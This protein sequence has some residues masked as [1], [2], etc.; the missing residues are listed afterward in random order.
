[1]GFDDAVLEAELDQAQRVAKRKRDIRAIIVKAMSMKPGEKRA[2]S[3]VTPL[4]ARPRRGPPAT[5]SNSKTGQKKIHAGATAIRLRC[6]TAQLS[7]QGAPAEHIV[8]IFVLSSGA[9]VSP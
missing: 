9:T 3:V 8:N 4:V 1:M 5:Q 7:L 6:R 2:A